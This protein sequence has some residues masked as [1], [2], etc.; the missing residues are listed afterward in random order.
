MSTR[1]SIQ[2]TILLVEMDNEVRPLITHNLENHGYTLIVTTSEEDAFE[3]VRDN[4]TR[5][6]LILLNQVGQSIDAFLDMG[7]RIRASAGLPSDLPIV[8]IAERYEVE[9]E[10]QDVEVD[11]YEFVTY[12]EDAQQLLDLLD[13]LCSI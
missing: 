2:P 1:L 10:G 9:Q 4:R 6:D 7:R 11:D 13:R 8:V 12:L 3:H 5:I